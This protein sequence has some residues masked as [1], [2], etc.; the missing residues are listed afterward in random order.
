MSG[1]KL[2]LLAV[3]GDRRL[4]RAPEV[5]T[6]AE[7]FPDYTPLPSWFALVGPLGLP[8]PVVARMQGELAKALADPK[9]SARLD[10][11]GMVSRGST[12]EELTS[13]IRSTIELTGRAVKQ[14]GIQPQ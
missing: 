8:Q 6:I 3:L 4:K 1:G 14:L 5:P 12:P 7:A 13:V 11:L 10:D 9:V 2:K